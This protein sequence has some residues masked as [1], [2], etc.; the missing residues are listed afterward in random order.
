MRDIKQ[1]RAR[2]SQMQGDARQSFRKH[3]FYRRYRSRYSCPRHDPLKFLGL[4]RLILMP[5]STDSGSPSLSAIMRSHPV[6]RYFSTV[7][8]KIQFEILK[9]M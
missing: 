8:T 1:T 9:R 2:M 6:L 5:V 3:N 4:P 7:S